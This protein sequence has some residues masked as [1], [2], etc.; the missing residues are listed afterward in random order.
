MLVHGFKQYT[1]YLLSFGLGF[2]KE[3]WLATFELFV[4]VNGMPH[5]GFA[6]LNSTQQHNKYLLVGA[7]SK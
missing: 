6:I 2:I 4:N 5:S 3:H 7:C 1:E